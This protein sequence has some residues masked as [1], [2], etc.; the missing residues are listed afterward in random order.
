MIQSSRIHIP[1][2]KIRNTHCKVE[3]NDVDMTSR[4][5]DSSWILPVTDGI[6][7]FSLKISNAKGQYTNSFQKG[8]TIKFYADNNNASNLQFF[9][10][11]DFI[12]D[13][14]SD[15]GQFLVI[16]GRH[17]SFLLNEFKIC[18]SADSKETSEILKEIIAKL[19]TSYGFTTT[20]VQTSS[21]SMSVEWNYKDI[22]DCIL[23]IC[24]F[25]SFD[26]Y[27]DDDLDFHYFQKN[28]IANSED[29]IVEG[30]NFLRSKNLG[31]NDY[32]EKTRV[33][34]MG[35][36][37]NGLPIMFTAISS[38]EG[39][40]IRELFIKDNSAD[41]A[42]KVQDLAE[43]KLEEITSSVI[44]ANILSYGLESVNPGDNIWVILP[45]QELA[46]Q[47][48]IIQIHHQF[49]MKVGGW[50]TETIFEKK[51]IQIS[52]NIKSLN[53]KNQQITDNKNVNKF[54]FS[55]NFDY[56]TNLGTHSG[57]VIDTEK[58]ILSTTGGASGTW[59]SPI[60]NLDTNPTGLELRLSAEQVNNIL[61]YVSLD[62]GNNW[63]E[64]SKL[65]EGITTQIPS[66]KLL[67]LRVIFGSAAAQ[68]RGLSLLYT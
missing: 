53:Q 7:T 64:I 57:T 35:Q 22:W 6:G 29:A 36:D 15:K 4:I 39:D 65:G 30:Q 41:T 67:M 63:K 45:R 16:E 44:Q 13:E 1:I 17:R 48:K 12:K 55:Y 24:N 59:E 43:A 54:N 19:P 51:D 11:I 26:C 40:E 33:I 52:T 21:T 10:R 61:V 42:Q 9:G 68:L 14:I 49:G 60:K 47:Y 31:V 25:A 2:P 38:S 18:Y 62:G 20:N 46:G 66:G 23:E 5:L 3:I 8:Q 27:V 34:V 32:I 37:R 50:R 58:G 56:L 28:S